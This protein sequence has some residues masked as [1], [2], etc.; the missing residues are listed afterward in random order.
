[1][2]RIRSPVISRSNCAKDKSTLSVSLP[3]LVQDRPLQPV[4]GETEFVRALFR[5]YLEIGRVVKLKT[6]L[7]SENVHSPTRMS[8]RGKKTGGAS[9]SRGHL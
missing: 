2:S 6:A 9:I 8:R 7:D 1:L 3:M 5:R 4:E